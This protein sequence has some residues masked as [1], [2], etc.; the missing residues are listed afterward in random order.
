MLTSSCLVWLWT[1]GQH[2]LVAMTRLCG[3]SEAE[4]TRAVEGGRRPEGRGERGARS[5]GTLG[6][7]VEHLEQQL[8]EQERLHAEQVQECWRWWRSCGRS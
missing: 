3:K 1:K 5:S 7:E 4:V 2:K 6:V 8:V